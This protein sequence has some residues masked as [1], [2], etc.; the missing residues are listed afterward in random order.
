MFFKAVMNSF[1][2]CT[3]WKTSSA[4][5]KQISGACNSQCGRV[6]SKGRLAK[7]DTS[8]PHGP[9][10]GKNLQAK[11]ESHRRVCKSRENC[12]SSDTIQWFVVQGHIWVSGR[13]AWQQ[14][15]LKIC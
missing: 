6:A 8:R 2:V 9:T 4:A 12:K 13:T 1:M 10:C 5:E 7:L 14:A 11:Q 3:A 15:A